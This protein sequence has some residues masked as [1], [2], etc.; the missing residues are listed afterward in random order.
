MQEGFTKTALPTLWAKW[1]LVDIPSCDNQKHTQ[2]VTVHR[3]KT[4]PG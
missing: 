4:A 2:V 1:F 3:D